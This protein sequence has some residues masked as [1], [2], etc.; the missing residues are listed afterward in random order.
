MP[1][2]ETQ[3]KTV[4]IDEEYLMAPVNAALLV[5]VRKESSFVY[6]FSGWIML[7]KEIDNI[8]GELSAWTSGARGRLS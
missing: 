2:K 6:Y 1:S 5:K 8:L 3:L 7:A 4:Q